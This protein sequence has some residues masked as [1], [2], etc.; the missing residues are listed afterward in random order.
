MPWKC[1]EGSHSILPTMAFW[2]H[3]WAWRWLEGCLGSKMISTFP[4]KLAGRRL[5]LG[6]GNIL[7]FGVWPLSSDH[8][9]T[10]L[11]LKLS[12][13]IEVRQLK[14]FHNSLPWT[15]LQWF[16]SGVYASPKLLFA[17]PLDCHL[18]KISLLDSFSFPCRQIV[19]QLTYT[20]YISQS[21]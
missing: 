12:S 1:C 20:P 3:I 7:W 4:W 15:L 21:N 8:I 2:I 9:L 10:V 18:Q 17:T 5:D 19:V 13:P 14:V 11:L 16:S 6:A